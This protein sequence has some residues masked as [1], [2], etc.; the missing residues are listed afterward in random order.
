[1][2]IKADGLNL[3]QE[4]HKCYK[5]HMDFSK[6]FFKHLMALKDDILHANDITHREF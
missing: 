5:V 3:F 1:M 6:F 2:N 4:H